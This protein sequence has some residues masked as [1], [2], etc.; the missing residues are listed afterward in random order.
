MMTPHV[1]PIMVQSAS[2]PPTVP[3]TSA[4]SI[5]HERTEV[6]ER[7]LWCY[8]CLGRMQFGTCFL[9]ASTA[10]WF[11]L[12]YLHVA[13]GFGLLGFVQRRTTNKPRV[14]MSTSSSAA[15][16][17]VAILPAKT[18]LPLLDD[19]LTV[20]SFNVLLPNGNDG[21]WM[22]KVCIMTGKREKTA[23]TEKGRD[24]D[25]AAGNMRSTTPLTDFQSSSSPQQKEWRCRKLWRCNRPVERFPKTY[26]F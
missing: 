23:G 2:P 9:R 8:T 10:S 15:A 7:S 25:G 1:A 22:Y 24:A 3:W 16:P 5:Q 6:T 20:V 19:G 11:C 18:P 4:Q 21:W 17:A 13:S 26:R 14:V 12:V